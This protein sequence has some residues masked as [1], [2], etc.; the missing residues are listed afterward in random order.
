MPVKSRVGDGPD[1]EG[2][3]KVQ[4]ARRAA[5]AYRVVTKFQRQTGLTNADGL[6]TA[7]ADL[8]CNLMHLCDSEGLPF[9]RILARANTHWAAERCGD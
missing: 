5:S 6:D 1:R 3:S 7:I 9:D 2:S 8:V 4:N